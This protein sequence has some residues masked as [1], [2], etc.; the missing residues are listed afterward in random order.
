LNQPFSSAMKIGP[1]EVFREVL[2]V[3]DLNERQSSHRAQCGATRQ[4]TLE[5]QSLPSF[6]PAHLMTIE[7]HWS[8]A[9]P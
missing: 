2:G 7:R 3:C 8:G 4:T 6:L 1:D 9:L 5:Q